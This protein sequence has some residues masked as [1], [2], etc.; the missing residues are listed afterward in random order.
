MKLLPPTTK[1]GQGNIF[2]SVCQ[3]FCPQGGVWADTFLGRHPTPPPG[4]DTPR[5]DTPPG[6]DTPWNTPPRSSA[7]WEIQATNGST[8]PT[9][10]P[11]LWINLL[12]KEIFCI[13]HFGIEICLTLHSAVN[14]RKNMQDNRK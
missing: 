9:G 7:C 10:M 3:E 8:H 1:L 14:F 12:C 5:A 13:M 6:A 11:Y 4:A 2:R